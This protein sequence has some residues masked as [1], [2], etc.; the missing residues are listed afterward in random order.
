M[1]NMEFQLTARILTQGLAK[2]LR[3]GPQLP[4]SNGEAWLITF[5][6]LQ[7][8]SGFLPSIICQ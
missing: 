7:W 6:S 2:E 3:A 4:R 8:S 1:V 5:L